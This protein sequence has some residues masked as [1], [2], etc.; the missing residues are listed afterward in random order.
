MDAGTN[1]S[2]SIARPP[3]EGTGTTPPVVSATL[4]FEFVTAPTE[5]PTPPIVTVKDDGDCTTSGVATTP[6]T[7]PTGRAGISRSRELEDSGNGGIVDDVLGGTVVVV[8]GTVDVDDVLGGTVVVV[9]GTVDVDDVLG[10]TV[11][12]VAGTVDVDDVGDVGA[13]TDNDTLKL[14]V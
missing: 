11:V 7:S 6:P 8:A 14:L 10:G 2:T 13:S 3:S 12:V 5:I 1:P 9:A 4:L